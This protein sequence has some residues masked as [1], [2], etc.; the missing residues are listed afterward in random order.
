MCHTSYRTAPLWRHIPPFFSAS[1]SI[2]FPCFCT[3]LSQA[4]TLAVVGLLRRKE[5]G[6]PHLTQ[7]A[8][9]ILEK[10]HYPTIDDEDYYVDPNQNLVALKSTVIKFVNRIY[11]ESQDASK[12]F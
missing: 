12:D 9:P 8:A 4:G 2:Q 10:S 3:V 5:C 6:S 11:V 1:I 7:L